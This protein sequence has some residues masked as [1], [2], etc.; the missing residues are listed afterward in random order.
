MIPRSRGGRFA[1]AVIGASV[2]LVPGY[3]FLISSRRDGSGA[4]EA[5]GAAMLAVGAPFAVSVADRLFRR[6]R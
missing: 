6:L 1:A 4:T 3:A 5:V 2:A